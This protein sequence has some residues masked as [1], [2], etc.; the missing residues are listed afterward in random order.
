M[1][2]RFPKSLITLKTIR[3][4]YDD[5]SKINKDT[6]FIKYIFDN[7]DRIMRQVSP[8]VDDSIKGNSHESQFYQPPMVHRNEKNI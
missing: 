5:K 7:D 1:E 8:M 4:A 3:S 2:T 6:S